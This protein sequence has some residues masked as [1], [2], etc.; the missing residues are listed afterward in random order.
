MR[1]CP[2][3]DIDPCVLTVPCFFFD[4]SVCSGQRRS[5]ASNKENEVPQL[6]VS[7]TILCACETQAKRQE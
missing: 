5:G 1:S 2:D 7:P 6:C 3:T 4:W